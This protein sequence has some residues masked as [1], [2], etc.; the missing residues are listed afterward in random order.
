MFIGWFGVAVAII[1]SLLVV[2]KL[3]MSNMWMIPITIAEIVIYGIV[4]LVFKMIMPIILIALI[5]GV[6]YMS[7]HMWPK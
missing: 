7:Q 4:I 1:V 2:N 3:K 5:L 6:I